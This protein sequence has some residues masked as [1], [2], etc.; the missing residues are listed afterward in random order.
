MLEVSGFAV[1]FFFSHF[2]QPFYPRTN[3]IFLYKS[4]YS[5]KE[6]V[7]LS[8]SLVRKW[9]LSPGT[10]E[11]VITCTGTGQGQTH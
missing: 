4:L 3:L 9:S 2:G 5:K 8:L 1:I 11:V 7:V 6:Y 10:P